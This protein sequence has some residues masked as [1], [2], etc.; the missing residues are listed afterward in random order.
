MLLRYETFRELDRQRTAAPSRRSTIPFD[1]LR[2]DDEVRLRFDIPGV[3]LDDVD[4]T[5]EKDTL[6]L[7]IERS[8]DDEAKFIVRERGEGTLKRR[9]LLGENLDT[10]LLT[11]ALSN[12][13]LEVTLPVA[14]K[15]QARKVAISHK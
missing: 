12:G 9:V 8:T 6:T 1:A 10:E 3:T 5:V 2:S 4:L 13:V 7:T 14:E 15:A 11:A